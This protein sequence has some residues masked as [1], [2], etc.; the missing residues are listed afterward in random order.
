MSMTE[1]TGYLGATNLPHRGV[2][3]FRETLRARE[4]KLANA[5][6]QRDVILI[7]IRKA[8]AA[9]DA[10][11]QLAR[12]TLRALTKADVAAGRLVLSLEAEVAQSRKRLGMAE[13]QAA[14]AAATRASADDAALVRDKLFAVKCPD[15]RVVRHRGAS[16][17]DVRRR[18]Q[19]GYTVAGQVFGADADGNG[20]FVP[21]RGF[22]TAVLEAYESELV[23][24]LEARGISGL[25]KSVPPNGRE[26]AVQ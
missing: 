23:E 3:D 15:G 26:G 6:K 9:A 19:V 18:L 8:S 17:E 21:Q 25:G 24:W 7:D 20:G 1:T 10:G 11:D 5:K 16:Q 13:T 22:L 12:A 4:E 2:D 14:M